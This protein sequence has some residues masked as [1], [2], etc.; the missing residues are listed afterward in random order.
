[1]AL[2]AFAPVSCQKHSRHKTTIKAKVPVPEA[3]DLGIVVK[4]KSV[5]WASFNLGAS[6]PE[7]VGDY[8]AWG[9]VET[10][11][12]SK[13]PFVWQVGKNGDRML[14]DW[15]WYRYSTGSSCIVTKYCATRDED[16]WGGDPK[17]PDGLTKLEPED[18]A[19]HVLLGGNWRMPDR[20]EFFALCELRELA[21]D[22]NS[23]YTWED[24]ATV[25]DQNGDDVHGLRI[26]RK[27]TGATLFF[28]TTGIRM[29]DE[30][31]RPNEVGA[32]WYSTLREAVS[33]L[34]DSAKIWEEG[35]DKDSSTSRAF[36]HPIRPV[37]VE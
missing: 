7:E 36:A 19:A 35:V 10:H 22:A 18:D 4:G 11:Y 33:Y 20:E 6:R 5:K 8:Y 34:A 30:L 37:Y 31:Y 3:V 29:G 15:A 32:Y 12:V 26:T 2:A 13:N 16:F 23:D 9:E 27:S 24:W 17:G 14:Y 28:P 1:M 21:K 25:Q